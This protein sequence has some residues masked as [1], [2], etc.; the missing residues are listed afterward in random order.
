MKLLLIL[1]FV[2]GTASAAAILEQQVEQTN[3]NI[4]G[5]IVNGADAWD[6]LFPYQAGL[7]LEENGQCVQ[8]ATVYLGSTSRGNGQYSTVVH[9]NDVHIHPDYS[10]LNDIALVWIHSVSYSGNIQP[11]RLPSFNQYS[12][13]EGQW[14]ILSGWGN[15]YDRSGLNGDLKY[16]S[17]PIISNGECSS[18]YIINDGLICTK[19]V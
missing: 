15:I 8:A 3:A 13:Y 18:H 16:A 17:Q 12:N 7:T 6:G 5:H 2:I 10:S 9:Q 14:A 1:A 4:N 11:V 19:P